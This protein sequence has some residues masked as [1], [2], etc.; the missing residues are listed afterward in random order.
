[1]KKEHFKKFPQGIND[2]NDDSFQKLDTTFSLF[3]DMNF[4]NNH[5]PLKKEDKFQK[6]LKQPPRGHMD[7]INL[8][9]IEADFKQGGLFDDSI[10]EVTSIVK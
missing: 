5:E 2:P 8:S 4:G 9:I 6:I 7:S 1:M 10:A 3:Q